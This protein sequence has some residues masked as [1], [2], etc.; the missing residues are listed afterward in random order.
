M[1]MSHGRAISASSYCWSASRKDTLQP[2]CGKQKKML[3]KH[4]KPWKNHTRLCKEE[5]QIV[6]SASLFSLWNGP[7]TFSSDLLYTPTQVR[8]CLLSGPTL[9]QLLLGYAATGSLVI[10][11]AFSSPYIHGPILTP[12]PAPPAGIAHPAVCPLHPTPECSLPG[13]L[14][15]ARSFLHNPLQNPFLTRPPKRDTLWD[16]VLLYPARSV[17]DRRHAMLDLK[18]RPAEEDRRKYNRRKNTCP[19]HWPC[20]MHTHK[21]YQGLNLAF[22][23]FHPHTSS[24]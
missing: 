11:T 22:L 10:H 9:H 20:C 8:T 24:K 14:R 13:E 21:V 5:T 18:F 15:P 2:P 1:N 19:M 7:P 3:K 23:P 4:V 16:P 17:P 12:S 6:N